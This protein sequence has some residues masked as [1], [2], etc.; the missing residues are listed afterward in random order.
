M[1]VVITII[2][3]MNIT[4]TIITTTIMI[5]VLMIVQ[6]TIIVSIIIIILTIIIITINT[7]IS[8]PAMKD[9]DSVQAELDAVLEYYSKIKSE[10]V[11]KPESYEDRVKQVNTYIYKC[12]HK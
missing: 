12:I 3:F 6:I 5:I 10:C 9:A 2:I 11:A 1:I 8:T 7:I 4:I